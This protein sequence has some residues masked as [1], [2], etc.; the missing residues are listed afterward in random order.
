[1]NRRNIGIGMIALAAGALSASSLLARQGGAEGMR[2]PADIG[3]SVGWDMATQ[4]MAGLQADGIEVDRDALARGFAA[5]LAGEQPELS[6]LEMQAV[7]RNLEREVAAAVAAERM[8]SDPVF[9]ALAQENTRRSNEYLE[10]FAAGRGTQTLGGSGVHYRVIRSG[11]GPSP[12]PG[13]TIVVNYEI[14]TMMGV[15]IGEGEGA[16]AL[17][18]GL[19]EGGRAVMQQMKVGDRWLIALPPELA[20]GLGGRAPDLGPNEAVTIDVELVDV[21]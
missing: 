19:I 9:R 13:S 12:T 11:D 3:Y 2:D 6:E 10:R 18:D 17:L 16:E 8:A 7:L 20:Y 15:Q 14:E 21:R 5:A 1:M 4:A